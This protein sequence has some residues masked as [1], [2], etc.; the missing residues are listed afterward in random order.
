MATLSS[1]G[2]TLGGVI[3]QTQGWFLDNEHGDTNPQAFLDCCK[4]K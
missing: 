1:M 4:I 3:W 2:V